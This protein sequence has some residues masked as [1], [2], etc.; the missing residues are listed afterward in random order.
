MRATMPVRKAKAKERTPA[1]DGGAVSKIRAF[2]RFHCCH[3][4][5]SP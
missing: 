4:D 5:S 2:H 1:P 3:A